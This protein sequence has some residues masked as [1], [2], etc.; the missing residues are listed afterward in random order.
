MRNF[1][2]DVANFVQ[3]GYRRLKSEKLGALQIH[4]NEV[5]RIDV[6]L[7]AEV[8][9]AYAIHLNFILN[10]CFNGVVAGGDKKRAGA[11]DCHPSRS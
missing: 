7:F 6:E 2:I 9:Q 11:R 8:I 5:N 3:Q 10:I 4:P 1:C